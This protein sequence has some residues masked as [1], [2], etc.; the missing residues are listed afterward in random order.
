MHAHTPASSNFLAASRASL[1]LAG[2]SAKMHYIE[3]FKFLNAKNLI[4]IIII[5]IPI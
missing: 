5:I 4:I 3:T 2:G 1:G